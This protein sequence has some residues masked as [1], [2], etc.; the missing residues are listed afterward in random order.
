MDVQAL[1]DEAFEKAEEAV[2][3]AQ[4]EYGNDRGMCGFAWAH[5]PSGLGPLA[6]VMKADPR[7]D[8][9]Y[10]KGFQAWNPGKSNWQN[11]DVAAAGAHA[12]AAHLKPHFPEVYATSRL[13]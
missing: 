2:K 10:K 8:K 4:A 12:F 11:V 5:F 3:K 13:D 6:K 9:A 1:I 7:C